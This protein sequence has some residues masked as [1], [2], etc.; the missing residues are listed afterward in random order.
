MRKLTDRVATV[1]L[2]THAM[3]VVA[4]ILAIIAY[5]FVRGS[6]ALSWHFVTGLPAETTAGG[7]IGPE[8]FN[9]FY[10]LILTMIFTVPI[11]V[12]AGIYLQEYARPGR[13]QTIVI[14]SAESL[15]TVPSIVMG[16]FGLLIFIYYFHWHFSAIAGALTLTI[17]N[18]PSLMRVTQEALSTVPATLREASMAVGATKWQTILQAVLPSAIPSLTTGIVLVAGRI[19][20]ETAGGV[21]GATLRKLRASGELDPDAETGILTTGDGLKTA[22]VLTE[23]ARPTAVVPPTIKGMRA[24]GLL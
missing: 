15:A 9:S 2:W 7:G 11:A 21:T 19:F 24:A 1:V 4:I 6:S 8:I 3:G 12:A 10:I 18:L 5:L 23:T 22:D 16:L 20:G 13:F 17:M 14:F